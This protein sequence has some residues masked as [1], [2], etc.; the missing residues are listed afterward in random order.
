VSF[1]TLKPWLITFGSTFLFNNLVFLY[2]YKK[3]DNGI[4]DMTWSY[5]LLIPNL[6]ATFALTNNYKDPRAMLV[7]GMLTLWATRLS[8]HITKRHKGKEDYRYAAWR[9]SWERKGLN[10]AYKSWSY[11]F[12][13]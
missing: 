9:A 12:M 2:A 3:K 13:M 6:I 5:S 7:T 1:S 8:W 10:I 4:V 11:V